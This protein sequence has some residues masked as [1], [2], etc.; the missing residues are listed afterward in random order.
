MSKRKTQVFKV[1]D[2]GDAGINRLALIVQTLAK[3][4]DNERTATLHF[5]NSKFPTQ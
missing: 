3:M 4:D 2:Y 1:K 5:I